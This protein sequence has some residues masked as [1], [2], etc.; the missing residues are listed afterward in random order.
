MKSIKH[1]IGQLFFPAVFIH[2]TP[3][4]IKEIETLIKNY[5]VGGLTFFYSRESVETNFD[6]KK[7]VTQHKDSVKVLKE[8]V[9]HYQSVSEPPLLMSIDAEWGLGMRIASFPAFP[10]PLSLSATQNESLIYEVGKAIAEELKSVGIHQNLAPVVDI[11]NNPN[12]PVIGYRSFGD[13]KETVARNAWAYYQGMQS[14]GIMGCLKHFPGHGDTAVD[15]HL[16]LPVLHKSKKALLE[17]E[18]FPF[19]ELINYG[20]DCVMTGH[21]AIPSL[22][23]D[24]APATLSRPIVTNF[25]RQELGYDG[26]IMTDALNMQA[27]SKNYIAGVIELK[28]LEAG[29]DMLSFSKN[30]PESIALIEENISEERIDESIRRIHTLKEKA[31]LLKGKDSSSSLID[32]NTH[33]PLRIQLADSMLTTL[34]EKNRINIQNEEFAFLSVYKGMKD[35]GFATEYIKNKFDLINK[36]TITLLNTNL[37]QYKKLIIVLYVP[38]MKPPNNFGLDDE[39]IQFLGKLAQEKEVTLY[40]FGN[41]YTL[42]LLPIDS[43]SNAYLAYQFLPEL[44]AT[45]LKHLKQEL[46]AVGSLPIKI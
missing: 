12:N 27:V 1:K 33:A 40:I 39:I 11:N 7:G 24:E 38:S 28:A 17:K 45:V 14:V 44:E 8:M 43:I 30:I 6:R 41:P 19:T 46:E 22:D 18:V 16:G 2:D 35:T 10:Y 9:E 37:N 20:I 29:N 32:A 21:L 3:K 42:N 25:L 23:E 4:A 36:E 26:A 15:S 34:K 31:G 13:T 5:H